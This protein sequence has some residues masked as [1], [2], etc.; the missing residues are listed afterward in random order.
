MIAVFAARP[1]MQ[2]STAIVCGPL[3][4]KSAQSFD[5][6]S[7]ELDPIPKFSKRIHGI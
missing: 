4:E 1:F 3:T 2:D 5:D 6:L 7:K